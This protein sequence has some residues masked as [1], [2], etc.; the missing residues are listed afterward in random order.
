MMAYNSNSEMKLNLTKI[1]SIQSY[2]W[3]TKFL[4]D[5]KAGIKAACCTLPKDIH[6]AG[7]S[8]TSSINPAGTRQP[9]ILTAQGTHNN[10]LII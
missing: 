4:C 3:R 7:N 9:F 6:L 1:T 2:L 5:N 8:E 10:E